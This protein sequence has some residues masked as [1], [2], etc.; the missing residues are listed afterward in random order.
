MSPLSTR[1]IGTDDVTA[2]GYGAMGIAAYYGPTRPDEERLEVSAL[3]MYT[4]TPYSRSL[5]ASVP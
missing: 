3:T 5:Y 1:K 2:I 4:F